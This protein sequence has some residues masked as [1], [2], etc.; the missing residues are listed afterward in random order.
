MI[1]CGR[2]NEARVELRNRLES[3]RPYSESLHHR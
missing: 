1:E 3:G 2:L